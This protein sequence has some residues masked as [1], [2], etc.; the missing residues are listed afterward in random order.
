MK[1]K[2]IFT[3]FLKD[4]NF[5]SK[6]LEQFEKY[7]SQLLKWNKKVNLISRRTK[8]EEYWVK[9]FLD[10]ILPI[11]TMDFSG[12]TILDFGSGGGLPG[13]PI[14]LL[15]PDSKMYLLDSRNKKTEAVKNIVK[16]LDVK[17]CFTIVSRIED[18]GEKYS[19]FFDFVISR[20]VKIL[21]EYK[22]KMLKILKKDGKIILYKSKI[23]D[24]IDQFSHKKIIN[25]EIPELGIRNLIIIKKQ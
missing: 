3:K 20:S 21:P 13:I 9:H 25:Y 14:K 17:Q 11:E 4:N 23:M 16:V 18:L 15:Y 7:L 6:D 10:S 19:D 5:N 22:N 1:N 2:Q 24:D 8:G 12:K